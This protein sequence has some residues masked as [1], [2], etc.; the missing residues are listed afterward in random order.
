VSAGCDIGQSFVEE[1]SPSLESHQLHTANT[2]DTAGV[3]PSPSAMLV[4]EPA[5]GASDTGDPSEALG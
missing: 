4:H 3:A 1:V 2:V 5:T